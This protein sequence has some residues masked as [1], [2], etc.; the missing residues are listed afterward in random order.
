[1]IAQVRRFPVQ[2]GG[3]EVD[4][5]ALYGIGTLQSVLRTRDV[6]AGEERSWRS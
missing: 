1:M 3:F 6:A 4:G 2:A 5:A